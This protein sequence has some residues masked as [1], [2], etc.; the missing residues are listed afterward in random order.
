MKDP[1]PIWMRCLGFA[2][3]FVPLG[4]LPA[5]INAVL[6]INSTGGGICSRCLQG[7]PLGAAPGDACPHCGALFTGDRHIEL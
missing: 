6:C 4:I 1:L 7:Q 3:L 2:C 5:L